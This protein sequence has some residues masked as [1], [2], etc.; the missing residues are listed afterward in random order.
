MKSYTASS[1][2]SGPPSGELTLPADFAQRV[3]LIAQKKLRRQRLSRIGASAALLL[4]MA[5][6]PFATLMH[7][8]PDR[9]ASDDSIEVAQE[10]WH[11]QSNDAL[12]Y[13]LAQTTSPRPPGDYLLPNVAG[14]TELTSVYSEA[15]WQY[16]PNW[17]DSW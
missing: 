5:A 11:L 14:L 10:G 1:K 3:L 15:Y 16:D 6:I 7:S 13:E 4:L 8:G 12:A 17:T 2:Q 9:V